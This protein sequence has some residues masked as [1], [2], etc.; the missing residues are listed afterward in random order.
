MLGPRSVANQLD[1]SFTPDAIL[2]TRYTYDLEIKVLY[3]YPLCDWTQNSENEHNYESIIV[4]LSTRHRINKCIPLSLLALALRARAR[5]PTTDSSSLY[6]CHEGY[7][8]LAE[9]Y[10]ACYFE[11]YLEQ[12]IKYD[13]DELFQCQDSSQV[14]KHICTANSR[15]PKP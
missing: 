5:T 11:N 2:S 6:A 14:I 10:F 12:N 1:F 13:I 15:V 3:I 7:V 9:L 8:I 4:D